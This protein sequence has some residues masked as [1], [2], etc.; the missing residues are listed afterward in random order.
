ML[1]YEVNPD[2]LKPFVPRGTELD[3]FNG[4][5]LASMVGFRFL[6]TRVFGIPFPGHVNFEEVNLR[7]YV[8]RRAEEGWRRGVVFI[9][10]LVPRRV[11]A[12][13]A[14]T[15][16]GEPYTALPMRHRVDTTAGGIEAA[17]SWR[18]RGRWESLS[19]T[20]VG[21]P[22]AIEA[23][24][25]EEFI[26]EHYWGYTAR[27]AGCAEYQVE[28]PRWRVWRCAKSSFDADVSSLYGEQFAEPLAAAPVSAFIAEGSPVSVRWKSP[29]TRARGWIPITS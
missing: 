5:A 8:R 7:F 28:H 19:A 29:L 13:I 10:E 11:I 26:T 20:G 12:F 1:N 4:R 9:R 15:L 16:Y 6:N 23:G 25:E 2:A 22:K 17:F 18:R 3:F 21:Q 14:R 24:S 27:G